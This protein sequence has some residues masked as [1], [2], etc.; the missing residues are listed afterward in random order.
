VYSLEYLGIERSLLP[1]A[2]ALL[3]MSTPSRLFDIG[4]ENA[5]VMRFVKL[6]MHGNIEWEA[7]L[8]ELAKALERK[9]NELVDENDLCELIP[10][11][12]LLLSRNYVLKRNLIPDLHD[13]KDLLKRQEILIESILC[14]HE[15]YKNI[16]NLVVHKV[17]SS[18]PVIVINILDLA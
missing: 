9:C 2:I 8:F 13:A 1:Q 6:W 14:I 4:R 11:S 7:M 5:I 12:H 10:N 16:C 3:Y 17:Q 18:N 15:F